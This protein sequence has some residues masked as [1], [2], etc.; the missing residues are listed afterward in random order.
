[1]RGPGFI[2][3]A[4]AQSPTNKA[5]CHRQLLIACDLR[6]IPMPYDLAHTREIIFSSRKRDGDERSFLLRFRMRRNPPII[7]IYLSESSHLSPS[8]RA[9]PPRESN[10]LKG[11]ALLYICICMDIWASEWRLLG[12]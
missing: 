2:P 8:V 9:L 5:R 4:L 1:M 12:I 10:P 11:F 3:P 7:L 6:A